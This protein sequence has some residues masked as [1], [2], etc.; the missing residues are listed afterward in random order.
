MFRPIAAIFRLITIMLKEYHIYVIYICVYIYIYIY[1]FCY[2]YRYYKFF[3][4]FLM[5]L[6]VRIVE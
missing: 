5:L 6:F 3:S 4:R 2:F 1:E